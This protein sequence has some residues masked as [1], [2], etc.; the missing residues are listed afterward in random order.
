[1]FAGADADA[2]GK[3][4]AE[5]L[6]ADMAAHAP[7]GLQ[8]LDHSEMAATVLANAD[9]DGD[10][11][12]TLEE[13]EAARPSGPSGGPRFVIGFERNASDTTEETT[14]ADDQTYDAADT[15]QD[16]VVSMSELLA[17]LQSSESKASGFSTEV[18]D[19]L[20]QLLDKLTSETTSTVETAA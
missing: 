20:Q 1:M 6:A 15:N 7:P 3:L 2:D 16:G 8:D 10:G 9:S 17:S 11:A 12:L 5:E 14:E 4:T 13:F 18:S 19:L